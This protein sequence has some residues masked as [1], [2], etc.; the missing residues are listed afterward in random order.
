M[1]SEDEKSEFEAGAVVLDAS[2]VGA[3]IFDEPGSLSVLSH[4]PHGI[5]STVNISEIA[6]KAISRGGEPAA[7]WSMISR[8]ALRVLPFDE[9]HAYRAAALCPTT[10]GKGLSFADR[11]CIAVACSIGRPVLTA[12][13]KWAELSL[14]VEVRLIR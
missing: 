9:D 1:K 6:A 11:A 3:V 8:F 7:V 2:A 12:D 14:P 5:I 13:R 4:L 10:Q